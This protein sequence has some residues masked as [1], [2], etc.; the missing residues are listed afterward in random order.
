MRATNESKGV[1]RTQ[2]PKGWSGPWFAW[3]VAHARTPRRLPKKTDAHPL[4]TS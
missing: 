1:D 3:T 2:K 4:G